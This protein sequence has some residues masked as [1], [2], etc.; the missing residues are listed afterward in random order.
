MQ[1]F[2]IRRR[3][4]SKGIDAMYLLL[5][6]CLPV[7]YLHLTYVIEATRP[8]VGDKEVIERMITRGRWVSLSTLFVDNIVFTE[9]HASF[10]TAGRG[11]ET[12][13]SQRCYI[14]ERRGELYQDNVK[15]K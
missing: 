6:C 11:E 13:E 4:E 1:P 9:K 14:F 7:A 2:R 5:T 3:F 12:S 15:T 10:E 8:L